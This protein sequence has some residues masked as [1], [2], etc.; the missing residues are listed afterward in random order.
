M[1][2]CASCIAVVS[3]GPPPE[4]VDLCRW[5]AWRWAG[6]LATFLRAASPPNVVAVDIDPELETA[7]YPPSFEV[8]GAPLMIAPPDDDHGA[9]E[10]RLVASEGS[11]I[12]IDPDADRAARLATILESRGA[13]C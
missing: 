9:L 6:P 1:L 7:V 13:K 8:L 5:G 12:V 3:A 10:S 2:A 11:T 4:V